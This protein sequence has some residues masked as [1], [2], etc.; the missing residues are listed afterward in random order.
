M[1]VCIKGYEDQYTIN[2]NGD[3]KSVDRLVY[4]D[5][6]YPNGRRLQSQVIKPHKAKTGYYM[7]SLCRDGKRSHFFLHRLLSIHF[8][9]NTHNKKCVNHIDGNRLNN[10]LDN[11]EWCTYLE[12]N[13]HAIN[14][15]GKK[16]RGCGLKN[17]KKL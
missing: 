11:L 15:L 9:E 6:R 4:S 1:E 10:S 14:I 17:K 16:P 13:L 5:S 3:I 12:N 8:I 7:I 2:E